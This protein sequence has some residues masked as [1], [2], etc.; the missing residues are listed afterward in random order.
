LYD[1]GC[2]GVKIDKNKLK[3]D[4]NS[5]INGNFAD[6]CISTT[7][8]NRV[9]S[10]AELL[11]NTKVQASFTTYFDGEN[12]G[13]C[14]NIKL[15]AE[16]INGSVIP[17]GE[18]FS[19]NEV[20]GERSV[21]NGFTQAKIIEEGRF[22]EGIGGGVC[23]VSTTLYNAALLSGQEIKEYHPHS[24]KVGYVP[25]SRDAM[26]SGNYYDLK[27]KNTGLTPIY[28]AMKVGEGSI[29]CTIF[30]KSDGWK[31]SILSQQICDEVADDINTDSA[32]NTQNGSSCNVKDNN[33]DKTQSSNSGNV[34][35]G[36]SGNA[37][38]GNTGNVKSENCSKVKSESFLIM[39]KDGKI[40]KKFLRRDTYGLSG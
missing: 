22:V 38:S 5:S 12:K 36:S 37:K 20:V 17:A 8:T 21:K 13:R 1:E 28:V 7:K 6:V 23:Q 11:Q 19:F 29:T 26:V 33:S 35:S 25:L 16:K 2:D 31:Y 34:K 40:I 27:I 3:E 4:I 30:G 14:H 15:A 10:M 24:L 39:E 9:G 18:V 32:D